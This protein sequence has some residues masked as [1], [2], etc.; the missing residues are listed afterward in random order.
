VAHTDLLW[1]LLVGAAIGF[2]GGL[3]GKGGSAMATPALHAAGIPALA[4]LASPLPATIPATAVS[5]AAYWRRDLVD[6]RVFAVVVVAG[7]PAAVLG[8]L[9]TRWVPSLVLVGL[10]DV[11]LVVL[12]VRILATAGRRSLDRETETSMLLAIGI[13]VVV[14][15]VSGLLAN[16]GGSLLAPLLLTVARLPVR[17]ALGTSLAVSCVVAIPATI[18]HALLGH[19]DWAL[20]AALTVGAVPLARAGALVGLAVAPERLERA[21]GL[22]LIL[23]ALPLLLL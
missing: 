7:V 5:A 11:L 16:S 8:A 22:A 17:H 20:V 13:A 10:A 21:Y 15:G 18:V 23:L 12:G 6:R 3:F 2:L 4:A 14:G 1:G 9:A 19:I